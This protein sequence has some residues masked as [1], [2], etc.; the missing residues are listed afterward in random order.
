MRMHMLSTFVRGGGDIVMFVDLR[1][2]LQFNFIYI[3]IILPSC[4]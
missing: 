2:F 1:Y 4:L 3:F